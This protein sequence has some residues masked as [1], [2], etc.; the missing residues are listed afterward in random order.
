MVYR[1]AFHQDN[2]RAYST[3]L[4]HL[5]LHES[6][7]R[8]GHFG[9]SPGIGACMCHTIS[10]SLILAILV[11]IRPVNSLLGTRPRLRPSNLNFYSSLYSPS[12]HVP[13]PRHRRQ[14]IVLSESW[15]VCAISQLSKTRTNRNLLLRLL[16][17]CHRLTGAHKFQTL[18]P[19]RLSLRSADFVAT[20]VDNDVLDLLSC[21]PNDKYVL[22]DSAGR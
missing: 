8:L 11:T 4:P 18:P 21:P 12:R 20:N 6:A 9:I 2:L 5:I 14:C 10:S 1:V 16:L 17:P 22:L 7:T 3:R 15:M 19:S 13:R